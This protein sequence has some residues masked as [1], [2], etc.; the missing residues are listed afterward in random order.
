[1]KDTADLS[2]FPVRPT[3]T[4]WVIGDRRTDVNAN[5]QPFAHG[6]KLSLEQLVVRRVEHRSPGIHPF[7]C[8]PTH[9][10]KNSGKLKSGLSELDSLQTHKGI[11]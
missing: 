9:R 1:M 8:F 4:Q 7:T 10:C 2:E 5:A 3:S 6:G 11:D